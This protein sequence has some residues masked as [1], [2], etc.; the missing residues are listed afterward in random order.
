MAAIIGSELKFTW[1][2][3]GAAALSTTRGRVVRMRILKPMMNSTPEQTTDA[4]EFE[5]GLTTG[6][7]TWDQKIDDADA[8]P[9]IPEGTA[10]T[11]T[12][13]PDTAVSGKNWTGSGYVESVDFFGETSGQS[14]EICRYVIRMSGTITRNTA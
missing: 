14:Y 3:A 1:S 2:G 12:I 4:M 6:Q 7:I 11:W 9:T 10:G 5:P 8:Q 13:Y